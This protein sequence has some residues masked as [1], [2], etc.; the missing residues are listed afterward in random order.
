MSK[1][2]K[3]IEGTWEEVSAHG[4]DFTGR[5]VRLTLLDGQT[6]ATDDI[7]NPRRPEPTPEQAELGIVP[8]IRG[9]GSFENVMANVSLL[10]TPDEDSDDLWRAIA[11]DR[12]VRREVASRK[13]CDLFL[14]P[15]L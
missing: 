10:S 6:E 5:H 14:E 9:N 1:F 3:E 8:P 4:S 12:A 13:S 15:D 7:V 11:E 2:A